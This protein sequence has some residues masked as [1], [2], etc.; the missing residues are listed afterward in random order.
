MA[1]FGKS[2]IALLI[3]C[4]VACDGDDIVEPV[5]APDFIG[6]VLVP[7]DARPRTQ[8]VPVGSVSV[9]I[10]SGPR[11]GERV[12]TDEDGKYV[13]PEVEEDELH[14]KL[15]KAEH[16]TKEAIVHRTRATTLT[17]RILLEY[18][19]PQ[20]RPGTVL[21]GLAWPEYAKQ[22][23]DT[24]SVVSDLLLIR[25]E[26]PGSYGWGVVAVDDPEEPDPSKSTLLSEICH[27]RQHGV[28]RPR[29]G[30]TGSGTGWWSEWL[31]SSEGEAYLE[32]RTADKEEMDLN[33][34]P[35]FPD[36]PWNDSDTSIVEESANF[37]AFWWGAG[38]DRYDPYYWRHWV[39]R[40]APNRT[41]WL[42]AHLYSKEPRP[43]TPDFI[44][45]VL[46]PVDMRPRSNAIPVDSVS[47]TIVSGPRA[48]ERVMADED[49][50]Y[51]FPE[52]EEA[53]E[54]RLHIKL[55]KARHETKEVIVRWRR[56]TTLA[57]DTLPLEYGG[58]QDTPG[59][60]LIGL[61]W[62][63]YAKQVMD[64]MLVV[65]DLLLLESGTQTASGSYGWGVVVVDDPEEPDPWNSALMH[66][67]CHAHQHGVVR[68]R[69]GG[70]GSGTG[71][72][73]VWFA[74]PEAR[75]YLEA[76]EADREE[77]GHNPIATFPDDPWND[78]ELSIA[79]E[80]ANFCAFWWGVGNDRYDIEYW[81]RWLRNGA[82]NRTKW[83]EDWLYS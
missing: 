56:A 63:E 15:E 71:W 4:S 33:P 59:T 78:S 72:R 83:L 74:S 73:P 69:G 55:E 22:V 68:P 10:V 26:T 19:G 18:G 7:V 40:H 38:K 27:A 1:N 43:T 51:I 46:T 70:T 36:D 5:P 54:D 45:R 12:G 44:G 31:S 41:E 52:V 35:V 82:P 8:A 66:E 16:E 3:A 20:D 28:V 13:F 6:Q 64:T 53:V 42:K 37:C 57:N 11:A 62:Q 14:I 75:A 21:I 50:K 77:I 47:V 34:L 60:V 58:P 48:G 24:V 76:R 65:A 79:E 17:D 32:A 81:R 61:K 30:G 29:G 49:G 2:I 9:T 23:M 25:S 80:N 39:R 67:V